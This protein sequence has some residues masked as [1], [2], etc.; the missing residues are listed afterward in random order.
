MISDIVKVI[1]VM[2]SI[3]FEKFYLVYDHLGYFQKEES[4]YCVCRSGV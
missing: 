2:K 1:D 4:I 3:K